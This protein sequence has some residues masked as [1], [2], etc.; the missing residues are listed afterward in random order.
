MISINWDRFPNVQDAWD[1]L[2]TEFINV[3]DKHAPWK[4]IRV[5]GNHLPWIN[6][7]LISLFRLR[8]KA[9]S[10]F[11]QTRSNADWEVYRHLRN[12]SKTKVRNAKS[13]YYKECLFQ[14]GK[15]PKY[16]WNKIKNIFSASDKH[17]IN[18]IRVNNTILHDSLS[19][20]QSF[21]QH[22]SSVCST[23][24]SDSYLNTGTIYM[25]LFR[26]VALF[27]LGRFYLLKFR[28]LLMN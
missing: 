11:R 12:L 20:A 5:R 7:E 6:S 24:V 3:V 23:L 13:T 4:T 28:T 16:F 27:N 25:I 9:W 2:Y 18:Q 14:Y 17:L 19:I 10:V 15:N 1:F 21:N 22:F 8:D 26:V